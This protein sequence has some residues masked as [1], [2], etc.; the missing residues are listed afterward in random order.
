MNKYQKALL[1]IK[2]IVID[3]RADG[4]YH[5]RTVADF[6]CDDVDIL[7]E[8]AD[9]PPLKIEELKEGMWVWDDKT[10]S[11]IYIFELLYWKPVKAIIY[12]GRIINDPAHG[13]CIDFE[14]NR[15][16]RREVPQEGQE[17]E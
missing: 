1:A 17:N 6:Y 14:E 11:Y 5:P 8:L 16:Y 12:A 15:F 13:F 2:K 7:Q 3:E 10:K 9:N 4:F